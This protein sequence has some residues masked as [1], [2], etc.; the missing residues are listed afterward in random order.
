MPLQDV[1]TRWWST[2]RML[3]R[4]RWLRTA[5]MVMHAGN[6]I[7][8]ELLSSEQWEVLHQIEIALQTMAGFQKMLEGECYVTGSM[9]PLAVYRIRRAYIHVLADN[10]TSEPVRRLTEILLADFNDC[11]EPSEKS[12]RVAYTG[13]ADIGIVNRY[14]GVHPYSLFPPF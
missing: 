7:E 14:T 5:I 13:N 9:V 1:V 10:S 4:L 6:E 11:Y 8:C 2:F 12:G 3:K